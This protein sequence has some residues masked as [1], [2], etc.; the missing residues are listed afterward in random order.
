MNR[1]LE[2]ALS[3]AVCKVSGV[4]SFQILMDKLYNLYNNSPINQRQLAECAAQLD[5]H[6]KKIGKGI[7]TFR[8]VS[9]VWHSFASLFSHFSSSKDDKSRSPTERAIFIMDLAIMYNILPEIVFL[10]EILQNRNMTVAYTNKLISICIIL[11]DNLK[12]NQ[13]LKV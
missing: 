8:T 5:Q 9:A 10:S 4:N 12:E 11:I 7:N 3:D 1:R 13:G 6:V 2:L